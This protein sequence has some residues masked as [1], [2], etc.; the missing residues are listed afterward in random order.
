MEWL[1]YVLELSALWHFALNAMHMGMQAHL[2]NAIL[3]PIGLAAHKGMLHHIWDVNKLNYAEEKS[4]IWHSLIAH[5]LHCI[6]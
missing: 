1:D 4:L 2:G 3:D 5:L 6:M